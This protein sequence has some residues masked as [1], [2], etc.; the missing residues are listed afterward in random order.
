MQLYLSAPDHVYVLRGNHEY[1]IEY[2]GR[3]YGGVK[4][5]RGHQHA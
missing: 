3:I 4:P 1:Y 5:G 2:N